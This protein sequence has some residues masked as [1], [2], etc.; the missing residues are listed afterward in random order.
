MGEF[1]L[2]DYLLAFEITS[3]VLLVAGLLASTSLPAAAAA[4]STKPM[5]LAVRA[6][7]DAIT[8]VTTEFIPGSMLE[9]ATNVVRYGPVQVAGITPLNPTV[10]VG[11][12]I[13]FQAVGIH[14]SAPYE[15]SS[16]PVVPLMRSP[17]P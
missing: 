7:A 16:T 1:F 12:S 8:P 13:V 5:T 6:Q 17:L 3:I 4:P 11:E 2:T 14:G 15:T 10:N 9:M